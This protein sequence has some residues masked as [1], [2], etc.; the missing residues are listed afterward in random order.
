ML[1]SRDLASVAGTIR[2]LQTTH[3]QHWI[4]VSYLL[5]QNACSLCGYDSFGGSGIDP[6][7]PS[8]HGEGVVKR[9]AT[10]RCQGRVSWPR[11]SD[12]VL[13]VAGGID[14]GDAMLYV[15]PADKD[16]FEKAQRNGHVLLNEERYA[17]RAIDPAGVA[18]V[19]EFVVTLGKQAQ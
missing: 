9:Y 19:Q 16:L 2:D 5:V 15:H 4:Q 6:D 8:C 14:V 13:G 12:F 10:H 18:G 11:L 1:S 3:Q 17:V 7:C